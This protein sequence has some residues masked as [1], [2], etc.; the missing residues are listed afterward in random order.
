MDEPSLDYERLL[1]DAL[2][3]L[4]RRVLAQ[5]AEDGLPGAHHFY[6]SF[7][8]QA[9][10]VELPSSLRQQHPDELTIVLQHQF[11][12]LVVDDD[13][14]S[15]TLYFSGR[16][17]SLTVPFA[18]LIAFSDPAASFGLRFATKTE[19]P[20]ET[21]ADPTPSSDAAPADVLSFDAFRNR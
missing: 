13:A 4:V 10:G 16:P 9:P 15:L 21:E 7:A 3:G 19:V 1:Q 17:C 8:T 14:F 6:L 11:A 5:V 18:A 12:N 2:R 20:Q